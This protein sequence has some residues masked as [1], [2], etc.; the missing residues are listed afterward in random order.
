MAC[1]VGSPRWL[2]LLDTTRPHPGLCSCVL[3]G[4]QSPDTVRQFSPLREQ[5]SSGTGKRPV[6]EERERMKLRICYIGKFDGVWFQST[7]RWFAVLSG[8]GSRDSSMSFLIST[9]VSILWDICTRSLA[10]PFVHS[11]SEYLWSIWPCVCQLVVGPQRCAVAPFTALMVWAQAASVVRCHESIV[12]LKTSERAH[13][14]Q[15]DFLFFF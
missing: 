3:T 15:T 11:F 12:F 8:S 6:M 10:H 14:R 2:L 4:V 5:H 7:A 1:S 13:V 9:H